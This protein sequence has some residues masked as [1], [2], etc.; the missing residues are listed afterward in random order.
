M[1]RLV[2]LVLL[3][4]VPAAA[5]LRAQG[6]EPTDRVVLQSEETGSRVALSC[7]VLEYTGESITIR[8]GPALPDRVYPAS[9]V[10]SVET[11]QTRSHVE[12]RAQFV[13]GEYDEARKHL[14]A[15]LAEESRAWVRREI[16]SLLVRCALRQ[17]D[18]AA[19]VS[20]FTLLAASD[21]STF[22]FKLIPLY[23]FTERPDEALV[24]E[25]RHWV[26]RTGHVPQVLGAS[27]LLGTAQYQDSA[28]EILKELRVKGSSGIRH[29]AQAQLWRL[30][31]NSSQLD[32]D[33]LLRWQAELDRMPEDL[34]AGPSF[35]LGQA[36]LQLR[37]YERAAMALLWLPLVSDQDHHLAARAALDAAGALDAIG[38]KA[39][40]AA[41]YREISE[42]FLNTPY[43]AQAAA[44]VTTAD[45]TD[46]PESPTDHPPDA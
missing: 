46:A 5:E 31:L 27:V 40:A 13:K 30:E 20:N 24:N 25:A 15:A 23:W 33:D 26:G 7:T 10:L 34:R 37:Q 44:R 42:R 18:R 3:F 16:L 41:L 32:P 1:T 17:G 21:P 4:A 11:P 35:V 38:Q 19:A 28:A 9:Q 6:D 39:E 45:S 14:E 43:A 8:P 2:P 36:S 12:G 22:H 29:L